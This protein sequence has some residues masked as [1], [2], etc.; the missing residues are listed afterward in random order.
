[1]AQKKKSWFL[2]AFEARTPYTQ[3][4][5]AEMDEVWERCRQNDP[6]W[7]RKQKEYTDKCLHSTDWEI[8][9]LG[10]HNH[11]VLLYILLLQDYPNDLEYEMDLYDELEE[12]DDQIQYIFEL[13]NRLEE[14]NVSLDYVI[15]EFPMNF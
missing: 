11:G 14:N 13:L 2:D 7:D 3:P 9:R 10:S 12:R 1:M 4:T 8:G 15:R 5:K 6:D